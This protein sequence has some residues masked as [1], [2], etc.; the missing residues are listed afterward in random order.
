MAVYTSEI[1]SDTLTADNPVH[2]R[3]LKGY[4]AAVPFISGDL[5]E[6]GCGEGRGVELLAPKADGYLG[7][8]KIQEVVDKLA[9]EHPDL[10]F[11]QAVFPPLLD[12]ADS[13]VD[14]I[15]CFHVIEHIKNDDLL[16]KE[17]SRVLKPGGLALISTPNIKMSLTRNPWHI[18]EYTNGSLRKLADKYFGDVEMKG[19]S[20]NGKVMEYYEEN[21]RSV[22]KFKRLDVF[23]LE[24]RLPGSLLRIPYDI[25]NRVNRNQL[26]QE[27][28]GLVS[29]IVVDDYLFSTESDSNLDLFCIARKAI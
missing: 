11:K 26:N 16:V 25:L 14:T 5:L 19:I 22:A 21:K 17:M 27:N 20:G 4:H 1:A 6:L 10:N 7:L 28:A 18:R 9:N 29:E 12:V 23:N 15:V 24:Y 2:Q 8:D 3:L 13:S